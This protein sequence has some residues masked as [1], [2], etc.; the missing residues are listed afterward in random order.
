MEAGIAP[1]RVSK[2]RWVILFSI[3]PM[4]VSTEIMWLSLAPVS[5]SAQ[6][7]YGVDAMSVNILSVSYMLMFIVFTVPASW[8]I[9]RIGYRPSLIVGALLT[10]VFGVV[11]A[12]FAN[13]FA[14][15]LAA[16]FAI[17]IGQPF[18]L[19]ISTKVPANWFPA[20]ERS[21]AAGILTMAQYV[22][23]A[24]PMLI[25]P[26][27]V[28]Q[29]GIA[30]TMWVFAGIAVASAVVSVACTKERPPTPPPGPVAVKEDFS[31]PSIRK[32]FANRAYLRVLIVCFI[33]MGIFNTVLTVLET[34]LLPNGI[35]SSEAG[36]IGA[37]FVVAGVIGA[38]A[39]PV[40]SD[41]MRARI[42]FFVCSIIVL[43][44]AYFGFALLHSFAALAGIAAM[45]GF[46][47][48]GVAP[49][50][51]QHGSE[52]AYPV[53]EGTSLGI[54]L[55]MG[56]ISGVL[57]V[58]LFEQMRELSGSAL[59]PMLLIVVATIAELPI[60]RGMRESNLNGRS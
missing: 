58:Y 42:P 11:R 30:Y 32:L 55:L 57:F 34:I 9:D 41:R 16:Q 4:I 48:M 22:G 53:Q 25:S 52:V 39:L 46:M 44:P 56:Q 18:L 33:S 47:I 40:L 19:N 3:F 6:E 17:A 20:N 10:S 26:I 27:L 54:I 21:T 45:A 51:F 7:F 38:V 35:T 2:Y 14:I 37:L 36:V 49:I 31:V 29:R 24:V 60:V 12:A 15:V 5:S 28:E 13:D 43:I 59:V 50:L 23:F 8:A 1:T